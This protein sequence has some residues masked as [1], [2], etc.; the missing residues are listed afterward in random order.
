MTMDTD[1]HNEPAPDPLVGTLGYKIL[2]A[3]GAA[4]GAIVARAALRT[5]WRAIV[6]KAPPK[7]PESPDV[8]WIEA[9]S[10]AAASA[11]VVAVARVAAAR[12]VA[13]SWKRASGAP[14]PERSEP[15]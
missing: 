11:A 2:A 7:S 5:G 3:V 10:W 13:N 1:P 4:A 15:S 14:A 6:G 8:E 9:A 12:R